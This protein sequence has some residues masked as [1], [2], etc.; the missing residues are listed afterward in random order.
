MTCEDHARCHAANSV[1][2]PFANAKG[3]T[4]EMFVRAYWQAA[5]VLLGAQIVMLP[6]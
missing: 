3:S 2:V 5:E 6:M 1:C 4:A